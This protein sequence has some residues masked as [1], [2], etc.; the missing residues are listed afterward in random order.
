WA[1]PTAMRRTKLRGAR[2][3]NWSRACKARGK[4]SRVSCNT[5]CS[6]LRLVMAFACC[7]CQFGTSSAIITTLHSILILGDYMATYSTNEFRSGLKVM[8][9]GDPCSIVENEF[10]KH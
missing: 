7:C 4:A 2:T 9:Y 6:S 1:L 5:L 10:V 8:L 3:G